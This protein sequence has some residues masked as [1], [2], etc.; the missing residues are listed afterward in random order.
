MKSWLLKLRISN[1]LSDRRP[2]APAVKQAIAKSAALRRFEENSHALEQALK[3][4]LPAPE[5]NAPLHAA[6]MRAVRIA[7]QSPVAENQL[8]WPRWLPATSAALL[9]LCGAVLTFE[10]SRKPSP[11]MQ[12]V[13]APSLADANSAL[14]SVGSLVRAAPAAAL[15]P[16]FEEMQRLDRDLVNTKRVLLASVP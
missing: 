5:K 10:F 2:L 3:S 1:A 13:A 9:V 12:P 15:S 14:D 6:I 4:Q 11:A 16:W 7:E 8:V